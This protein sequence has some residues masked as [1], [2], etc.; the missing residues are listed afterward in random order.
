MTRTSFRFWDNDEVY[1]VLDQL[2]CIVL[3]GW[4]INS[5]TNM[6]FLFDISYWH[7]QSLFLLI[8][9]DLVEKQQLT[10]S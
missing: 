6:L 1:L 3:A 5:Q 4:N 8:N 2:V 7:S 10:M 9:A